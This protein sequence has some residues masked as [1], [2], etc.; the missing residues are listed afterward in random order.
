MISGSDCRNDMA[1]QV[2]YRRC[3]GCQ[4]MLYRDVHLCSFCFEKQQTAL[5]S[6]MNQLDLLDQ[7]YIDQLEKRNL[8]LITIN[9]TL[10]VELEGLRNV[11]YHFWNMEGPQQSNYQHWI[12]QWKKP[13]N[14]RR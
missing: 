2:G 10:R 14:V 7:K 12:T 4:V 5:A 13:E 9:H 11:E 6:K 3:D 1:T 8:E